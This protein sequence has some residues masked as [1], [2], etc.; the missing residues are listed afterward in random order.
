[1]DADVPSEEKDKR[2]DW[3]GA[4]L[5]TSGLVFIVF[6]LGQGELAEQRWAT[7][8]TSD[9]PFPLPSKMT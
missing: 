7:G 1:M 4:G 8:C 5:V 2:I 3:I 9:S 6:V